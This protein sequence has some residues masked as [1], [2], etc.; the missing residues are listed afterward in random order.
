MIELRNINKTF[1]TPSGCVNA[2][3]NVSL[4]ID[5][6]S[7]YGII[8]FSGAGKSTL[9]RCMNFLEVPD[10][11]EVIVGGTDLSSLSKKEL[12]EKRRKIGMIFQHFNLMPSRTIAQ[13]VAYPL[14]SSRLSR[15]EKQEKV[16]ELLR[17][18][19]LEDKADSYPSQL[20]G[21]QKQR[22]AIARALI[23]DPDILLCDE[24]TSA[25]DPITTRSIL[26]LLKKIQK[27]TGITLV[28]ITHQMEVVK[29]ICTHAA[30]M[31]NGVCVEQGEVFELFANPQKEVTR[32]FL[33][34]S[35]NLHK[36]EE[37]LADSPELIA[38]KKGQRLCRFTFG[39]KSS[40]KAHLASLARD[41]G[42]LANILYADVE[43]VG[44]SPVGGTVA[45]LDGPETG[46]Q[47]ALAFLEGEGV[48]VEV[49]RHA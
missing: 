22:A 8:G 46:I 10:T 27:A 12:R 28:V 23:S 4:T 18:V 42:V 29:E 38:L 37:Q 32:R 26:R 21:G 43:Y 45:I 24:A 39:R 13:N 6:G 19:E 35:T 1:K 17:L 14:H 20:S 49:L 5:E 3:Q 16:A 48:H 7:I 34:S 31:E 30:I 40:S 47:N 44:S 36:I 11:G 2:L 15:Q 9:V 41:Y 33:N 25:L